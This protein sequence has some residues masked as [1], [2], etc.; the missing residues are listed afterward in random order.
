[1]KLIGTLILY[2]A[3]FAVVGWLHIGPIPI[4]IGMAFALFFF[5]LIGFAKFEERLIKKLDTLG[6]LDTWL[7]RIT[8]LLELLAKE[9]LLEE[10]RHAD[11]AW[12]EMQRTYGD[13]LDT[14][15][16]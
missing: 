7:H 2:F 3:V 16:K 13:R 8:Y 9:R 11:E 5:F 4:V 15:S 12:E 14:E 10:K 6:T 1:M